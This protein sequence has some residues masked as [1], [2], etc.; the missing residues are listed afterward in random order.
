[1]QMLSRDTTPAKLEVVEFGV[2]CPSF[3]FPSKVNFHVVDQVT[4]SLVPTRWCPYARAEN[5][6]GN[7]NIAHFFGKSILPESVSIF[8]ID[9]DC[10]P[11]RS[12]NFNP[13]FVTCF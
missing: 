9:I 11:N 12:G 13:I 6:K 1:M 8:T 4:G 10:I 3:D 2:L 5:F 7:T